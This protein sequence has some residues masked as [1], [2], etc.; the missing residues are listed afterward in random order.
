MFVHVEYLSTPNMRVASQ[1]RTHKNGVHL[2]YANEVFSVY[3]ALRESRAVC[4]ASIS[5]QISNSS[6]LHTCVQCAV[7]MDTALGKR[8][9]FVVGGV[10]S[11]V[12]T[13]RS[14]VL[15][16]QSLQLNVTIKGLSFCKHHNRL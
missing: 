16:E 3:G 7:C 4:R 15:L 10:V 12:P 1:R 9:D 11:R 14:I 8:Y 6:T 2:I 13:M 5:R